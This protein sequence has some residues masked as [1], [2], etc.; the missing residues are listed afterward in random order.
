MSTTLAPLTIVGTGDSYGVVLG[1]TDSPC[2]EYRVQLVEQDGFQ[3]RAG[4]QG[5]FNRDEIAQM[6]F[7]ENDFLPG[8][9][10]AAA[11]GYAHKY[12]DR[13]SVAF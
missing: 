11:A 1:Q 10:L 2:E 3:W 6:A 5:L 4:L 12:G 9:I 8:L 7:C 13:Y